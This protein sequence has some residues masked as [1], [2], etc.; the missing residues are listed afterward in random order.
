MLEA[1]AH[2]FEAEKMAYQE[3]V[4]LV[5]SVSVLSLAEEYA[6]AFLVHEMHRK[7]VHAFHALMKELQALSDQKNVSDFTWRLAELV[8]KY[9]SAFLTQKEKEE[10]DGVRKKNLSV[11]K[12]GLNHDMP[13][14][15]QVHTSGNRVPIGSVILEHVPTWFYEIRKK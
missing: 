7:D 9:Y 10:T 14:R 1:N 11:L 3:L 8:Q 12:D 15:K 6:M 2:E 5:D 13:L 4:T